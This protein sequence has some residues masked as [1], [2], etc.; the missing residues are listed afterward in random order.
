MNKRLFKNFLSI[1]LVVYSCTGSG[2]LFAS[3]TIP[4]SKGKDFWF[5][6]P[7]N[8]HTD[9][10]LPEIQQQDSLYVFVVA[11]RPCS[12]T[13]TRTDIN[14]IVTT[15]NET[16]T[17]PRRIVSI[18]MSFWRHELIGMNRGNRPNK[19]IDIT[20][21]Q[22]QRIAR[23]SFHLEASD[24]VTVYAMSQAQY[25][26][27]AFLVLPTDA[28]GTKHFVM[29]YSNDPG[30]VDRNNVTDNTPSQYA[31][32]APYDSTVIYVK[33][34][35]RTFTPM[36]DTIRL[37][38]GDVYLVQS[39]I[40]NS[41]SFDLTGS[42]VD[43][44][45][46]IAVFAGHQRTVVPARSRGQ[47]ESRDCLIEQMPP[48]S[49]WGKNALIAPYQT[50]PILTPGGEDRFR[51][52][53]AYD[54]TEVRIDG[55]G[56]INLDKGQFYEG[57]ANVPLRIKAKRPVLVAQFKRTSTNRNRP[58]GANDLLV[59]D[60]FMMIIS[61]PE[62]F[63]NS[64]RFINAQAYEDS[65]IA[66]IP[67]VVDVY[68][69]QF[70]NV[71]ALDTTIQSIRLDGAP[72]NASDFRPIPNTGYSYAILR[73]RDGAHEIKCDS[74][75]GIYVYGYGSANSYGYVGG[76]AFKLYDF[77]AP[78][79]FAD[80]NCYQARGM[81]F[82]TNRADSKIE[83]IRLRSDSTR[84]VDV[85]VS[86]FRVPADSVSYTARLIDEF[87]DG[88]YMLEAED[89][90]FFIGRRKFDIPG[91]TIRFLDEN[92]IQQRSLSKSFKGATNRAYCR[93]VKLINVGKFNQRVN[94]FEILGTGN[95]TVNAS[96]SFPF[97]VVPGDTA[98]IELCYKFPLEGDY[99]DT[100]SIITPCG[101][102]RIGILDFMIRD[103]KTSPEI[104]SNRS[105]CLSDR[106]IFL[107]DS[108]DFA[109]GVSQ[110]TVT[111]TVNV[112]V[113]VEF[114]VDNTIIRGRV[115]DERFDAKYTLTVRDSSGN[116]SDTTV[117]IPG[118]S[119]MFSNVDSLRP[120]IV[121]QNT[122]YKELACDTVELYN[123]GFLPKTFSDVPKGDEI[124]LNMRV[125][126]M[127]SIPLHQ[128]PIILQPGE[129]RRIQVCYYPTEVPATRDSLWYDTLQLES[130]CR[131]RNV[132]FI[133][134]VAPREFSGSA[135][136][137]IDFGVISEFPGKVIEAVPMPQPANNQLTVNVATL[138][139]ARTTFALLSTLGDNIPLGEFRLQTGRSSLTFPTTT[140]GSGVYTLVVRNIYG[141][142]AVPCMIVK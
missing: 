65:I 73:M 93:T 108:G 23:Q 90:E 114:S 128:L 105:R 19:I 64:Y 86:Q 32:V 66:N 80:I 5:C 89:K 49:T 54:S 135:E 30:D 62:Q 119:V 98:T 17:D 117:F 118:F 112:N 75:I 6:F 100:I 72:V 35:T 67:I 123:Y 107:R 79:I 70:V 16:I 24:D 130:E 63:L 58:I 124:Y 96:V 47:L 31:I 84:N 83:F 77:N 87:Q 129:K 38:R 138:Y 76:M 29:S 126:T 18:G 136:C 132:I 99:A 78:Q 9:V 60:P 134:N 141:Q 95:A 127:F 1:F 44:N 109:S 106:L 113:G 97:T 43:A 41:S 121:F 45:K 116:R 8:Y 139:S 22:G 48:V 68:K 69:Q 11:E 33:N 111:D 15:F 13:L 51:V 52:L 102:R 91:F 27:D 140:I 142:V 81:I 120:R 103:D 7:P 36:P 71:V 56:T 2:F 40:G 88:Y 37:N 42:Q 53:A 20:G 39:A 21:G 122:N 131:I 137:E 94:Q 46:P 110:I 59:G 4:D 74:G 61:P 50:Q 12:F 55:V 57:D 85:Q 28:L 14:G 133:G 125:N 25:T 104:G 115:I 3:D 10:D 26:S 82:D 92:N 101:I 34:S